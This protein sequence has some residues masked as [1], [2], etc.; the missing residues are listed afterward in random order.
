MLV[1]HY[2]ALKLI[3]CVIFYACKWNLL[4]HSSLKMR[5][6]GA[7]CMLHQMDKIVMEKRPQSIKASCKGMHSSLNGC[8]G[9]DILSPGACCLFLSLS[10]FHTRQDVLSG[11]VAQSS[12]NDAQ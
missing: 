8:I 2:W 1:C 10:L 7:K 3:W 4:I 11:S 9:P 6:F 12:A 5:D